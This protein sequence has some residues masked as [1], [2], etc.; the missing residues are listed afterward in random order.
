MIA[1][2][3]SESF[4]VMQHAL[5]K[6]WPCG[7]VFVRLIKLMGFIKIF[8]AFFPMFLISCVSISPAGNKVQLVQSAPANSQFVGRVSST[9][10]LSGAFQSA[11]YENAMRGALNK[12]GELGATHLVLDPDSASRFW[13]FR[14]DVRGNAYAAS[15]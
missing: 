7:L 14:Q 2:K 6:N 12:A 5:P 4:E 1:G 15:R 10:P 3:K 9:S 8:L 11:S 13:G